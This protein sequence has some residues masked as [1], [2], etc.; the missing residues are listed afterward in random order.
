MP[1]H[2]GDLF[3][4]R[5]SL[6]VGASGFVGNH[7]ARH[8]ISTGWT[9]YGFDRIALS[10][11]AVETIQGDLF[12]QVLLT[13][14]LVDIQPQ[15]IFHLAGVLKSD[16]PELL[17]RI[18]VLG[19]EALCE[20]ILKAGIKPLII[21]SSSSA[22]YGTGM[23]NKPITEGFK[24]R[25]VTHYAISK[26]AQE[27]IAFRYYQIAKL[28]V[29]CVRAF[30]IIGPGQPSTLACSAFAQQIA[31]AE[32]RGDSFITTGD[33][34]AYRDFV[35]VRDVAHAY[36]MTALHGRPGQIYNV[37]S[38]RAVSIR[39]CLDQLLKLTPR[40]FQIISDPQQTQKIDVSIQLGS[41]KKLQMHSGW[42]PKI[43]L[44]TSLA[45]LLDDWRRIVQ[46]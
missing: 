30:N 23:G 13:R 46:S 8:L 16:Q 42:Q 1:P 44:Q 12:N 33:L 22:V 41:A 5:R 27:L 9:V 34:R 6:I 20:A 17:Y 15:V 18:H 45:D 43:S 21:V 35:D 37:C 38:G 19:T 40:S 26:L 25:P 39:E 36:E 11:S 31:L 24:L 14:T 2:K 29:I 28:P 7:L 3:R 10:N 4:M 32:L